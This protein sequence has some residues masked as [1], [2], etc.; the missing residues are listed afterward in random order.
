MIYLLYIMTFHFS[1]F[2]DVLLPSIVSF[3]YR[4]CFPQ[5]SMQFVGSVAFTQSN[6]GE[7]GVMAVWPWIRPASL[8]N[9]KI[10][11]SPN[12]TYSRKTSAQSR[13]LLQVMYTCQDMYTVYAE[14]GKHKS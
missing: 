9:G 4:S 10:S 11:K 5:P 2:Q 14:R 7:I 12:K 3:F 13:E 8:S 6:M 1:D